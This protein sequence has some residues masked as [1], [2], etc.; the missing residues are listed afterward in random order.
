MAK[1]IEK[2]G[3][4]YFTVAL[5][6]LFKEIANHTEAAWVPGA[7]MGLEIIMR[8]IHIIATQAIKLNDEIIL[9]ALENMGCIHPTTEAP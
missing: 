7:I 4:L 3:T 9:E 6:A 1:P 5:P 8:N 2:Q